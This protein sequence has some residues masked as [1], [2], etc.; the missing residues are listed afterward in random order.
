MRRSISAASSCRPSRRASW[1]RTDNSRIAVRM[2]LMLMV[3]RMSPTLP[4]H[5]AGR[6]MGY[7]NRR[8]LTHGSSATE[9]LVTQPHHRVVLA[10]G[11]PLFHRDQRVVGDLDVF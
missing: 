4:F 8:G 9:Q 1:A 11:D 3:S 6:P 10:V 2:S 7:P 5:L